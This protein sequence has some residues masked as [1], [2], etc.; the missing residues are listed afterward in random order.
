M[1]FKLLV[2]PILTVSFIFAALPA[3]SQTVAPYQ[4][5]GLPLRIGFGPSSYDVD[6]GQGRMWGGTVW[7]DWYPRFLPPVLDGLGLETEARDISLN[8]HE[9]PGNAD[10]ERSGQA[11][12]RQD[13]FGAGAIYSWRHFRNFHPYAKGLISLGSVDFISPSPTYS[14][15]TRTV[16]SAGGG[17]EYRFFRQLWARADYEYQDWGMLLHNTLNPQGFTAGVSYDFS[18]P[19]P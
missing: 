1:R 19:Q 6:W 18:R 14:H 12:T 13:T 4:S 17:F 7:A 10:P 11:N 5:Q 8:K 3:F 15:D 9:Q 16:I 2:P